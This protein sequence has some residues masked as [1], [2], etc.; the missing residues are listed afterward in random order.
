MISLVCSISSFSICMKIHTYTTT[1]TVYFTKRRLYW[2]D[3]HF[4]YLLFTIFG[5]HRVSNK[6]EYFSKSINKQG[7]SLHALVPKLRLEFKVWTFCEA[8]MIWK[9]IPHG[10]EVYWCCWQVIRK[11]IWYWLFKILQNTYLFSS[12]CLCPVGFLSFVG[13]KKSK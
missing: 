12:S 4:R 9:N 3:W 2:R 7:V 11:A 6:L 10:S 8:H 13:W 1:S 5:R